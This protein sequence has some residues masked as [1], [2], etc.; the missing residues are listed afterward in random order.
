MLDPAHGFLPEFLRLSELAAKLSL[1]ETD[2]V[3]AHLAQEMMA[4][5]AARRLGLDDGP[6]ISSETVSLGILHV[7]YIAGI[8]AYEREHLAKT[9]E[10]S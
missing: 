4:Y 7:G 3:F 10:G 6:T 1:L 9:E 2:A 8:E 5:L